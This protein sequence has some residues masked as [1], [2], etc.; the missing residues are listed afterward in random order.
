MHLPREKD[1]HKIQTPT[2]S[3]VTPGLPIFTFL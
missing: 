2:L 3:F 1:I